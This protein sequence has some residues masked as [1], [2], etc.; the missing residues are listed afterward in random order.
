MLAPLGGIL[1][2]ENCIQAHISA[3]QKHGAEVLCNT[4]VNSWEA[5]E[6]GTVTVQDSTGKSHVAKQMVLCVG[7]W[8]HHL[9]P[10]F[11]GYLQPQR[12]VVAWFEVQ[13]CMLYVY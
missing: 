11:E 13:P 6:D 10:E 12:Q 4:K 1:E 8:T 2:S 9:V 7:S 3:A 5:A